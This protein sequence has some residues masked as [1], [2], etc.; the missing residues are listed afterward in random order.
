M[1]CE[2]SQVSKHSFDGGFAGCGKRPA[3]NSVLRIKLSL[4]DVECVG[5][6]LDKTLD[7]ECVGN[8]LDKTLGVEARPSA[9]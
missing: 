7:V 1:K 9:A 4:I 8:G 3:S 5:N 2:T 6:G